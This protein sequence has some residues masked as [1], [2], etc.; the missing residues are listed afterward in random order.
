MQNNVK[1]FLQ[2]CI[3]GAFY[4]TGVELFGEEFVPC[5]ASI[6]QDEV[7]FIIVVGMIGKL[8]GRIILRIGEST[9][10]AITTA[11]NFDDRI[12]DVMEQCLFLGEFANILAGRLTT[13]ANNT[14]AG[15]ELRLTPPAVFCG[16]QIS[17]KTPSIN[18]CQEMYCGVSGNIYVDLGVEGMGT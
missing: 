18:S 17:V 15:L 14:F 2:D 16:Y 12:D 6:C 3:S 5:D 9:A 10:A 8:S 11:M 1:Q 7:A 13:S 4:A